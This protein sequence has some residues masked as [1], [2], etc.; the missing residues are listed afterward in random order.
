[1]KLSLKEVMKKAVKEYPTIPRKDWVVKWP[2]QVVLAASQI[3]WTSEVTQ[4]GLC[5]QKSIEL[6]KQLHTVDL[7][8]WKTNK[9]CSSEFFLKF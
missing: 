2:G 6:A 4:V 7:F 5:F 3:H 1:M 9:Y 8:K